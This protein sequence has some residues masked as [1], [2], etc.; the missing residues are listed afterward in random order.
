MLCV[1]PRRLKVPVEQGLNDLLPMLLQPGARGPCEKGIES[2]L[3]QRLKRLL[4]FLLQF[5]ARRATDNGLETIL[6][7]QPQLLFGLLLYGCVYGFRE[8]RIEQ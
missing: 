3:Q 6:E 7:A 8:N 5:A 4:H 2:F 1:L